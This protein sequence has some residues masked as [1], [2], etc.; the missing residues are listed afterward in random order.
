MAAV[1][2]DRRLTA[3]AAATPR[4][5]A[6]VAR[7][8]APSAGAGTFVRFDLTRHLDGGKLAAVLGDDTF[9]EMLPGIEVGVRIPAGEHQ[10]SVERCRSEL[11]HAGEPRSG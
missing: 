8:K 5:N 6:S 11:S 4:T 2:P 9:D 1:A 10:A 3:D 7:G